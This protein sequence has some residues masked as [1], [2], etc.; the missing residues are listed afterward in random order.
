MNKKFLTYFLLG[1]VIAWLIFSYFPATQN[2]LPTIAFSPSWHSALIGVGVIGA[3]LFVA[4]QL[5]L[6]RTTVRALHTTNNTGHTDRKE[7]KATAQ[8]QGFQFNLSVEAFWTALPILM[9]VVLAAV[10]YKIWTM[11]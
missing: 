2:L 10:G 6:V 8:T 5:W 1:C 9:T 4:I 7:H 3:L 11:L